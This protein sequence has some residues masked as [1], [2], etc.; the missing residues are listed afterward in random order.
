MRRST[1]AAGTLRIEART[2]YP[3]ANVAASAIST[4]TIF[5]SFMAT[6]VRQRCAGHLFQAADRR[7]I[8][9]ELVEVGQFVFEHR[10]EVRQEREKV[11]CACLI[12]GHRGFEREAR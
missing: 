3:P 6:S 10:P 7:V 5:I 9:G 8:R 1:G 11:D 12:A 4:T 2:M